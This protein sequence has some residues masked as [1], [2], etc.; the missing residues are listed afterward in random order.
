[1]FDNRF[2]TNIGKQFRSNGAI[3][4]SFKLLHLF[5]LGGSVRSAPNVQS[6][7]SKPLILVNILHSQTNRLNLMRHA[8]ELLRVIHEMD[9]FADVLPRLVH[10]GVGDEGVDCVLG[11]VDDVADVLD[12]LLERLVL[13]PLLGGVLEEGLEQGEVV[14]E[15]LHL[16]LHVEDEVGVVEKQLLQILQKELH[17]GVG[18]RSR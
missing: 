12:E 6:F 7:E 17:G 18:H 8:V 13:A 4:N 15:E 1:M 16:I 14:V 2:I 11:L 5:L 9:G 3:F 10:G